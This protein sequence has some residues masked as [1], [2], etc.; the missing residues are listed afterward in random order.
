MPNHFHIFIHQ[1]TTELLGSKFIGNLTNS[2]TKS[3]NKKHTRS[4]VLF[5]GRTKNKIVYKEKDFKQV[6][7]YILLNPVKAGLVKKFHQWKYSS[8]QELSN[9]IEQGVTDKIILSYFSFVAESVEF[10]ESE[11]YDDIDEM[12]KYF[13]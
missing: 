10:I 8:A 13:S 5:Q 7:K 3:I 6:V 11:E 2:Y 9:N 4:G 1:T 12:N